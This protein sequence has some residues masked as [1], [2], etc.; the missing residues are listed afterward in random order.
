MT[1]KRRDYLIRTD[2]N[3]F[4]N[5]ARKKAQTFIDDKTYS[6]SRRYTSETRH[7]RE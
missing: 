6:G 7:A 2:G 1:T 3:F 4:D 5:E